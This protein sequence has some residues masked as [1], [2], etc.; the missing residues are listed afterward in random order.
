MRVSKPEPKYCSNVLLRTEL[1][2]NPEKIIK[3][4]ELL[5]Y[6]NLI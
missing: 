5:Y 2:P 4:P 1:K 6:Y 3:V